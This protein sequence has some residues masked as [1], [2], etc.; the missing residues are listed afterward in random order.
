MLCTWAVVVLFRSKLLKSTE[1][2]YLHSFLYLAHSLSRTLTGFFSTLLQHVINIVHV[3]CELFTAQSDR[4]KLLLHYVVEELLYLHITKTAALVVLLQLVK[5]LI[6]GQ[7]TFK[8]LICAECV[9]IGKY[10]VTLN[11]TGVRNLYMERIGEHTHYFCLDVGGAVCKVNSVA[12]RLA[13]LC[14]AVRAGQTHTS[15]VFGK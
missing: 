6:I 13:H 3:L 10:R 15:L 7:I 11:M 2:I 1:I 4:L 5:V 12:E 9:K 8:V 14:L